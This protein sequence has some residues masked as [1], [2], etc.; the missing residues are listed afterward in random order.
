M[1]VL[2]D[3]IER[4]LLRE[5]T[6]RCA[7]LNVPLQAVVELTYRCNLQCTHCYIDIE[8]SRNDELSSEQWKNAFA[9]LKRAG[10][11]FLLFT[12]GEIMVREDFL[13]IAAHG[14]RSGFLVGFFT[15]CTMVDAE[16]A[17]EMA[18]MKPFS[19]TTSLYG[20]T[21]ET[22]DAV[23]K[24]EGSFDRTLEGI[25]HFVKAGSPPTVQVLAMGNN[26][27]ELLQAV[28]LIERLGARP[29]VNFAMAPSKSGD[30]SPLSCEVTAQDLLTCGWR[31]RVP[32]PTKNPRPLLCKAG[33]SIC[34]I[35]PDGTV[36][37][38]VMLPLALGKL[39]D[40]SFD[41]IWSYAPCAELRY[42]RSMRR[43][44]LHACT[45]C[46]LSAYCERCTGIAYIESGQLN[47][48]STSACRQ[49]RVRRR[50]T[51]AEGVRS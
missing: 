45:D 4:P 24:V 42:L 14:R 44:D 26:V 31:P 36:F 40:T 37:P 25:G 33:K 19:L 18:S 34:S 20:A 21:P 1:S 2:P 48:P 3:A 41:R 43:A 5:V 15:N 8:V 49:A 39:G 10:T 46:G 51:Q 50:L 16:V 11:A 35:S 17:R 30:P 28:D 23:T 47:G 7:E 38:C 6:T 12:G 9:Q 32:Q 29:R 22:H 27:T 13:E